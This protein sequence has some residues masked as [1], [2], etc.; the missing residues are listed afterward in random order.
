MLCDRGV[1]SRNC[2]EICFGGGRL[3]IADKESRSRSIEELGIAFAW[4]VH[5]R[6]EEELG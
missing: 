3:S 1:E 6:E 2:G 4:A 5:V